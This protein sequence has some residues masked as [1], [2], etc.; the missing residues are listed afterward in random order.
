MSLLVNGYP[1][2]SSLGAKYGYIFASVCFLDNIRSD[3][4]MDFIIASICVEDCIPP[5]LSIV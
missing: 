4:T 5:C 3:N 2:W 1:V